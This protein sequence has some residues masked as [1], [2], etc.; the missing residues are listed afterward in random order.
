MEEQNFD[1]GSVFDQIV[2]QHVP[3]IESSPCFSRDASG[4]RC[5]NVNITVAII[6]IGV[7][8]N[9]EGLHGS[10]LE[11]PIGMGPLHS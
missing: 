4:A 10:D 2:A 6:L 5:G 7:H 1:S 8:D 11:D 3:Q 9:T